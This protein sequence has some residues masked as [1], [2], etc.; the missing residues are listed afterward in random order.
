MTLLSSVDTTTKTPSE[1][2][3][4]YILYGSATGNSEQIAKDLASRVK[5]SSSPLLDNNGT[6]T[7]AFASVFCEPMQNFKKH[8]DAWQQAPSV[9]SQ[10]YHALLLVT[11]TTGNGDPPENASR[12]L[13]HLKRQKVSTA[14]VSTTF[15]HLAYSVLGLGDSNYDKFNATAKLVDSKLHEM[16]AVRIQPIALADEGTGLED[17]VEPWTN[18]IVNRTLQ[19]CFV[20]HDDDDD[21][22]AQPSNGQPDSMS[23]RQPEKTE[24]VDEGVNQV[25][26]APVTA[27]TTVTAVTAATTPIVSNGVGN[28]DRYQ[29]QPHHAPL[30]H[31]LEEMAASLPP[32]LLPSIHRNDATPATSTL[33]PSTSTTAAATFTTTISTTTTITTTSSSPLFIMYGSATGNSEH[34][35]KD[36]ASTFTTM[37]STTKDPSSLYFPSVVCC[38]MDHYKKHSNVL[39]QPSPLP[40]HHQKNGLIIVT[41]TTG[42]GDPPENANGFC[43]FLKRKTTAPTTFAHV[44]YA[45]LGLGDSNYDQ[46]GAT[47][48]LVDRKLHELGGARIQPVAVADEGTGLE[49]VVEP[50]TRDILHTMIRVCSNSFDGL[51]ATNGSGS[52]AGVGDHNAPVV[53]ISTPIPVA[54]NA[55]ATTAAAAV[56]NAQME[57]PPA[58]PQP[59]VATVTEQ[60]DTA[61]LSVKESHKSQGVAIVQGLLFKNTA[62]GSN[63]DDNSTI[64]TPL[65][66]LDSDLPPLGPCL[67]TCKWLPPPPTTGKDD[68]DEFYERH[69]RMSDADE[70]MSFSTVSSSAIYYTIHRPFE[71]TILNARYLTNSS[72][73]DPTALEEE[74]EEVGESGSVEKTLQHLLKFYEQQFPLE[75]PSTSSPGVVKPDVELRNGKRVIELRLSLPDDYTLEYQ[76]GD[77]LGLVVDNTIYAVQFI[78][79]MLQAK[80]GV[81]SNQMV[82]IDG[83]RAI[84]VEEVVRSQIDLCSPLKNKRILL[85]LSNVATDPDE[86]AMLRL[87]ASKTKQGEELFRLFIEEQRRTIVDVLQD[88]PSCQAITLEGLLSILP[89]IPPRYYS[90]SSSPLDR[91]H[92]DS[93]EQAL[94]L[95]IAFSVVDYL[96]PSLLVGN[97]EYGRRRIGGVATRYLEAICTPWLARQARD[98]INGSPTNGNASNETTWH[99]PSTLKIFPKPSAE[100]RLPSNLS[101]PLILIGPGTGIAPFMGFLAHRLA[102]LSDLDSNEAASAVVE[103]TWRGG[104]ELEADELPISGRDALGLVLG[105]DYRSHQHVGSVNVF[106]GCRHSDH[107]WLY[108][109]EMKDYAKRGIIHELYTAF[110]RDDPNHRQYVQ[111]LMRQESTA[112]RLVS[113]ILDE[114]AS[115]Y[116]CGDGNEMAKDVQATLISLLASSGAVGNEDDAKVYLE[117]MKSQKRFLMDI[118]TS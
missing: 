84:Y 72:I 70:R 60:V 18:E 92:G 88:F 73:A 116:L 79:N 21:D 107:D 54:S 33:L 104:Y 93:G 43:R 24:V 81:K 65:A 59:D 117:N 7:P 108:Q 58:V 36:L 13:R 62:N 80:H 57:S 77:S 71:T 41:S 109:D 1:G 106:F 48:K 95:T 76:P 26:T 35:A 102:Q 3:V 101:T 112:K 63:A 74:E 68:E 96:T 8:W 110:S 31:Q 114:N 32:S 38:P 97:D 28:H 17:V 22:V 100:F 86:H 19:F 103:G 61:T 51:T 53:A 91:R 42:N 14:G 52:H 27:T 30:S 20:E 9:V 115:V 113:L 55:N 47:A 11:S 85:Y 6:S 15:S 90:V 98:K 75:L 40:T 94:S 45:V 23:L 50:W 64:N 46:F 16:G 10:K 37:L 39:L 5:S 105:A 12:F 111:D 56:G 83:K 99:L 82:S 25:P 118:W 2:P 34:I 67:S 87:L 78:L 89:G 49:D 44:A 69:R 66:V 4:L 29:P